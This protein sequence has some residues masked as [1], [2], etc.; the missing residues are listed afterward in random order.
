MR[1]DSVRIADGYHDEQLRDHGEAR[2]QRILE[3]GCEVL[4]IGRDEIRS[5]KANDEEKYRWLT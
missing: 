4:G 5:R 1:T 2:A 3:A